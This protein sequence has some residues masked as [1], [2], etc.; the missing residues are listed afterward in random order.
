MKN[1][2]N[3]IQPGLLS[4][5]LLVSM[6]VSATVYTDDFSGDLS[7]WTAG[8]SHLD[9][10]SIIGE[11][12]FMDG[13]GHLTGS[14][15]WGVIQFNQ[16]LGSS[17]VA[18]W[19]AK[20]ASY[21]YANFVLFADSPWDFNTSLGYTDRGYLGWLDINDPSNPLLD[22]YKQTSAGGEDLQTPQRNISVSPDIANNQWF[23]WKVEMTS[24]NLKVYVDNVLYV[25]TL[26][27]TY[28]NS[29]YKIGLSFGEDST[30]YIDNFQVTTQAIPEPSTV[31]LLGLGLLGVAGLRLKK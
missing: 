17:F 8:P 26:D 28:A 18:T 25:D 10:Y 21:D 19:D 20:I 11:E 1:R 6:N 13:Y 2:I 3:L 14:G 22:I 16:Q 30:G 7:N 24:G 29:N 27:T 23:S 31:A 5:L 15:G 4:G 9:S 12:L